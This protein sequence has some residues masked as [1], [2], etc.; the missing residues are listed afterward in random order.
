MGEERSTH[1]ILVGR[2]EETIQKE[3]GVILKMELCVWNDLFDPGYGTRGEVLRTRFRTC[4]SLNIRGISRLA[5]Q[6][7]VSEDG[8]Y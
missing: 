4:G 2:P 5:K 6:P 1:K 8:V 7:L 3:R